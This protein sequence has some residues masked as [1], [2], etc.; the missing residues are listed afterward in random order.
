MGKQT[1]GCGGTRGL[2]LRD[3]ATISGATTTLRV[4]IMKEEPLPPALGLWRKGHSHFIDTAKKQKGES[5]SRG[6]RA[7]LL[8][9]PPD[10]HV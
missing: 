2:E 7:T 9:P 3:W 8:F 1:G 5:E 6:G 10:D 4:E